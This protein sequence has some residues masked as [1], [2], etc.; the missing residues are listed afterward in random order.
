MK[1]KKSIKQVSLNQIKAAHPNFLI[2]G[3]FAPVT[4]ELIFPYLIKGFKEIEKELGLKEK[5]L[6][7][8]LMVSSN[9]T[10]K[11][12]IILEIN[13]NVKFIPIKIS[14]IIKE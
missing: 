12:E 5:L 1:D 2:R 7:K 9:K 6:Q 10:N 4:E 14:Q 11:D 8:Q 3:S 13:N